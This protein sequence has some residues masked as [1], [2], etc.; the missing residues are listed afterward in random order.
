MN[1]RG[2]PAG[3]IVPARYVEL[4]S[5]DTRAARAEAS[6]AQCTALLPNNMKNM[7]QEI[8]RLDVSGSAVHVHFTCDFV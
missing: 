8:A 3:R 1:L 5:R 2:N 4:A 7:R 6:L